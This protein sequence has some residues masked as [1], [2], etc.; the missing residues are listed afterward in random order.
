MYYELDNSS[1][2]GRTVRGLR[3]DGHASNGEGGLRGL[4]R[5]H[6][7]MTSVEPSA[8]TM[9][10]PAAEAPAWVR[11]LM[12]LAGRLP[13]VQVPE[14]VGARAVVAGP[15]T[16]HVAAALAVAATRTPDLG[17]A[18]PISAGVTVAT[19]LSKRFTDVHVSAFGSR[20][21]LDGTQLDP[22]RGMLPPGVVLRDEWEFERA[23]KPVPEAVIAGARSLDGS[24]PGEWTFQRM[25]LEPVVVIAQR[26]AQV[27]QDLED[28]A[29]A[30]GWWNGAQSLAMMD[31][32]DGLDLWFRRPV[33]VLSPGGLMSVPWAATLP[34]RF[35]I[36]VGFAAWMSPVRHLWAHVP[37]AL[38]MNQ[39][40]G[41]VADFRAWFDGTDFPEVAL[42]AVRNLRRAGITVNAF[43]EPIGPVPQI[44]LQEGEEWEF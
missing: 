19:V 32:E 26:P 6:V 35:V 12:L 36:V 38:V 14:G 1:E 43:G 28:L 3:H 24:A 27:V 20:L 37:Q 39:R 16:R 2:N 15:T 22:A 41:D 18:S 8:P 33:I 11:L 13:G 17:S 7:D 25:C 29:Q 9:L 44:E 23:K 30:P 34:V 10:P 40:S 31:P 4:S 5:A 21:I 42:P